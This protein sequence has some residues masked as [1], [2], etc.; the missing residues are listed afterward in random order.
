MVK[1]LPS[2]TGDVRDPGSIPWRRAWQP[3]PVFLPG[4]S[5]RQRSV[6][7][8]SPWGLKE[9]DTTEWL[10]KSLELA[11]SK[12][13]FIASLWDSL[14]VT[15]SGLF[16]PYSWFSFHLS[17]PSPKALIA[18]GPLRHWMLHHSIQQVSWFCLIE[19]VLFSLLWGSI[20][21]SMDNLRLL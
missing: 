21:S 19:M 16:S 12:V 5:H 17:F 8:Y 13:S 10:D 7:G 11:F 1:N 18:T 2:I 4:K 20:Q 6:V 9:S 14:E 3:T 15:L